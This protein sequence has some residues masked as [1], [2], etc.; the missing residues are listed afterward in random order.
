[1]EENDPAVAG[2]VARL[3]AEAEGE[4][5]E[6][7]D[8][9]GIDETPATIGAYRLI[10]T[11]GEG[12]MGTVFLAEQERPLRR[13][14][15]L[16]LIRRGLRTREVLARFEIER[17]SLAILDHPN[18]ARVFDAGATP[19][20]DPYFVMEYISGI[21]ITNYCDQHRLTIRQRV[22]LFITVCEGVQHAHQK[23]ILHRDLKPSNILIRE[24]DG[25]PTVKI[26][27]FGLAKAIGSTPAQ[28]VDATQAGVLVG[29]PRYMSP[30]QMD[31]SADGVDTRAD[32]YSPGIVLHELL[33]GTTPHS[34]TVAFDALL[35][36]I[37]QGDVSPP[38]SRFAKPGSP[39][40]RSAGN[41]GA[42]H[43]TLRSQLAGDLDW[44]TLKSLANDRELRYNSASE[45]AADL[46]RHLR[47]EPVLARRPS[48][49]Y[50]VQ[51]F[52][53]RNRLSVGFAALV[54]LLVV[55]LAIT[56]TVEAI[57]IAK[58]RDRAN[59]E[60]ETTRKISEF[61]TRMFSLP[62]PSEARGNSV[63]AREILDNATR[64]MEAN[65]GQNPEVDGQLMQTMGETY[66]GLGLNA[67]ARALL[68]RAV[69]TRTHTLGSDD[70]STLRSRTQLGVVL[71]YEGR[72]AESEEELRRVLEIQSRVLG[73]GHEDSLRTMNYLS[74]ALTRLGRFAEA[75]KVI[76]ETIYVQGLL[77]GPESGPALRS[78]R[79]LGQVLYEQQNNT[80]AEKQI[81]RTIQTE[82][83]VL[84]PEH[85]GTLFSMNGLGLAL[86][87]LGRHEEAEE[88]FREVV[89]IKKRV[90]GAD[91][92]NTD[93]SISN[94]AV[95]LQHEGRLREALAMHR[96]VTESYERRLG[97]NHPSTL[98]V[99]RNVAIAL[100]DEKQFAEAEKVYR[101]IFEK[102]Q[103]VLGPNHPEVIGDV[104]YLAILLSHMRRYG[105][106]ERMFQDAIQRAQRSEGKQTLPKAYLDYA[107]GSLIAGKRQ[108]ALELL[109]K[110]V[111]LG[112]DPASN[113]LVRVDALKPLRG[114]AGFE[115]LVA[116]MRSAREQSAAK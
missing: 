45:F 93:A 30:E 53:R 76:R 103:R 38:S 22:E 47:D 84:G 26:I 107:C 97:P 101:P 42:N 6:N 89:A 105:E 49:S 92:E 95:T 14:V 96:A 57:R 34:E 56:M 113:D 72:F 12:G 37:R 73:P 32:V 98:N 5:D 51:K 81:R 13:R 85:P 67:N 60:A 65:P 28:M 18:I 63:T 2:E 70:P 109:Q 115:D 40:S 50:R 59:H 116:Q 108:R 69:K 33:T 7:E 100:A 9:A 111:S 10:K 52:V 4:D 1:L 41:W 71:F 86:D 55:S 99:G 87:A 61:L 104:S 20:G 66:L 102:R 35:A 29:T 82:R 27:D 68:E 36:H 58:E 74:D 48:T 83:R 80:D 44:I 112:L 19:Q 94:L 54:A 25:K 24:P 31:F 114:D 64:E 23:A 43:E 3:L 78:E 62:D 75:E 77:L 11:I 16:K 110:S 39:S 79:T 15:A 46:L 21:S 17:Q 91:H 106:A 88:L 90:L 8:D